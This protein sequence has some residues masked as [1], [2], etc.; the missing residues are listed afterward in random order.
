MWHNS[1]TATTSTTCLWTLKR[2]IFIQYVLAYIF[3]LAPRVTRRFPGSQAW[4]RE[5]VWASSSN[6]EPGFCH[7]Q[8][9]IVPMHTLSLHNVDSWL[10]NH[11]PIW[12]VTYILGGY[13]SRVYKSTLWAFTKLL[14][15]VQ[16]NV[17]FRWLSCTLS[18]QC[19][20]HR[21]TGV[22]GAKKDIDM[23]SPWNACQRICSW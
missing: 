3:K 6:S 22:G 12:M 18:S 15:F 9:C 13:E 5:L 17:S 19:E 8:F 10:I 2:Q 7:K 4:A 20:I 23:G 14:F 11:P 21:N 1:A 16:T